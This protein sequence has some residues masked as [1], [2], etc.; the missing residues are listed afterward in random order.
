ML[1]AAVFVFTPLVAFATLSP[2]DPSQGYLALKEEIDA[3]I[4]GVL[5]SG[6]NILGPNVAAFEEEMASY[7]GCMS[8][9]GVNSGTDALHFAL[10]AL[11]IGPG[12]EV[13]MS[14]FTFITTTESIGERQAA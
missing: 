12:D 1:L 7:L 9:V 13:I 6:H 2:C 5:E 8:A 4:Q 10:R 11:E 3:A 14:L